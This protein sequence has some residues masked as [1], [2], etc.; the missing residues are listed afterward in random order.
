MPS[1]VKSRAKWREK[2][3][4]VAREEHFHYAVA[5]IRSGSMIWVGT[6]LHLAAMRLVLGS[7][8]GSGVTQGLAMAEARRIASSVRLSCPEYCVF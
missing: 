2:M 1:H 5:D 4:R 3:Q 8:C 6:E 7:V